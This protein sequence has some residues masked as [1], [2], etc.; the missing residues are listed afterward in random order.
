M[1]N[2]YI[3]QKSTFLGMLTNNGSARNSPKRKK[4]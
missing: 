1:M 3:Y 2:L 4:P